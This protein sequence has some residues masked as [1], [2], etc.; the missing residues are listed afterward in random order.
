MTFW[1]SI[2]WKMKIHMAKKWPE[3]NS[4]LRGSF[5]SEQ[6][7]LTSQF[8][9]FSSQFS[10]LSTQPKC[11]WSSKLPTPV[12]LA[13]W[14]QQ[15]SSCTLPPSSQ[16]IGSPIKLVA[17]TSPVVWKAKD[18]TFYGSLVVE[19]MLETSWAPKGGERQIVRQVA[20]AVLCFY[21][22]ELK[23]QSLSS[24]IKKKLKVEE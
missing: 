7:L 10:V 6:T 8:A 11:F 5:N 22:S 16:L 21:H 23:T 2:L 3:I 24:I 18:W 15:W 20:D 9:P 1:T 12:L 14:I 13:P 4:Y 19:I 17:A